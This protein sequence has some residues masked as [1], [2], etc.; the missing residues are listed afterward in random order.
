MTTETTTET[1]VAPPPKKPTLPKEQSLVLG[2]LHAKVRGKKAYGKAK[3]YLDQ[4]NRLV[5]P[6][7]KIEL[8]DG[9][10]FA[11]VDVFDTEKPYV[12][13]MTFI[14]RFELQEVK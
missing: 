7:R 5:K 4:L 10:K 3:E 2:I 12:G 8:A 9:R 11:V 6:G 1:P 13:K 14:D